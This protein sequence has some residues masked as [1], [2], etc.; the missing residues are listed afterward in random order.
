VPPDKLV[1]VGA[2]LVH[3]QLAP[4]APVLLWALFGTLLEVFRALSLMFN[5]SIVTPLAPVYSAILSTV[6]VG[7]AIVAGLVGVS[8]PTTGNVTAA[9]M[10]TGVVQFADTSASARNYGYA[11][12]GT[13]SRIDLYANNAAGT[14]STITATSS[15]VPFTW[16]TTDIIDLSGY[17]E[18]A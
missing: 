17:Y 7:L 8:L 10:A 16:A 6:S 5:P 1:S 9:D 14:Y 2:Q 13:T 12:F 4:H 3:A 15:T 11:L 18:T